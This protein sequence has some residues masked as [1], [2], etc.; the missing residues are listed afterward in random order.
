MRD[1]QLE[2][3]WAW[4]CPA[5]GAANGN[6]AT[7]VIEHAGNLLISYP[8]TVACPS[9]NETFRSVAPSET[10]GVTQEFPESEWAE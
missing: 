8:E 4:T 6:R 2:Y 9:C 5:C 3:A 10:E 7:T 1:V